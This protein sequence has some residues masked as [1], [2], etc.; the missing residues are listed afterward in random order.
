[1]R[2]VA[3]LAALLLGAVAGYAVARAVEPS[4]AHILFVPGVLMVG[5]V[6]GFVLGGR[7]A[8]DAE[9][10]KARADEAKARRRAA[11][12]AGDGGATPSA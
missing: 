12:A 8:R 1:M 5:V 10:A 2:R 4:T 9:A 11:R 6:I 7:A 3:L